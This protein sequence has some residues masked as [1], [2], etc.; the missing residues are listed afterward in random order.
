MDE[1]KNPEV[2]ETISSN[3]VP[4]PQLAETTE[5]AEETAADAVVTEEVKE[6]TYQETSAAVV[7]DT[8]AAV[9]SRLKDIVIAGGEIDRAEVEMLKQTYYKL[10]NAEII[11]A[12]DAFVAAG[13]NV[14]DFMPAADSDEENFKAQLG[15]IRELRAE[16]LQALEKQKQEGL[17]KKLDIIEKIKN[18]AGS[19]EEADKNY[20][21]FKNLQNEWKEVKMVPAERATE[22]WKNYQLYVEQFYDQLRLNHEMRAYDFKKNLEIKTRLCES[23][24]KLAEIEDPVS[25]FHQLQQLHQEFRETGPVEKEKREEIWTRFKEASTVVNKRHQQ[26]F[27]ALKAREEENLVAKTALCEKVEAIETE[28]IKSFSEWETVTKQVLDLQAQWKTIGFTPKKMNAKIFERFRAACDSFFAT[29]T[30]HFKN[31]RETYAANLAAKNALCEK[32]EAL[33]DSTD[34]TATANKLIDLQ[35]EWKRTGPVNHKTSDV[36]W[37][38]FNDACNYF[39]EKKNAATAGQREEEAANWEKKNGV[40]ADLEKL[41]AEPVENVQQAVREL[42][43]QWNEIGHVP[44]RKKEKIYKRYREVCDRI[45]KEL[46]I[47]AGRRNLENFKKNVA[48]KGGNELTRERNRLTNAYEAK[49]QEINNYETNLTFLNTKSKGANS[50]VK[51]INQKIERLKEDLNLILDKI[52]AVNEQ[53]KVEQK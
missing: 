40:I 36:V 24:E 46:H 14:E 7:P 31:L 43:A 11:A 22:L 20:D 9:I 28:N 44:F 25:A 47:S 16:A 19:P 50:F 37:K 13:G 27:E 45:Y 53:I 34:W 52:R 48:E 51:E 41:L 15:R 23:A 35:K 29:K 8:K 1:N 5:A 33:K 42:Q 12:R 10:H 38:R 18:M 17:A 3:P 26:H 21:I 4:A 49:K 39:F 6:N 32:A 2:A 30:A